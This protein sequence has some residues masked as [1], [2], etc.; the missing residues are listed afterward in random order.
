[1]RV[2]LAEL[3]SAGEKQREPGCSAGTTMMPD[4]RSG[5]GGVACG[6]APFQGRGGQARSHA[7]WPG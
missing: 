7:M 3:Q 6:D 1:M 2:Q 4:S 5:E